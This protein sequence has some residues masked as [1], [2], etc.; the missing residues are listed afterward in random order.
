MQPLSCYQVNNELTHVDSVSPLNEDD[1]SCIKELRDVLERH[2]KLDR[3]GI[4]LLHKHFE[5]NSDEILLETTDD[6]K[7]EQNIR[8]VKTSNLPTDVTFL[9]TAW[10]LDS[11]EVAVKCRMKCVEYSG[12]SHHNQHSFG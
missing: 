1:T 2:G 9:D 4:H 11:G 12:G 3:I 7:R 8:V 10:R 5:L 6:S